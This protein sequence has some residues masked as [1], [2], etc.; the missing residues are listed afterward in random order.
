LAS[1]HPNQAFAH[2]ATCVSVELNELASCSAV[3]WTPSAAGPTYHEHAGA[4]TK[5][6]T[7]CET[8][9]YWG[10]RPSRARDWS[11]LSR[12]RRVRPARSPAGPS[13]R[14]ADYATRRGAAFVRTANGGHQHARRH[15]RPPAGRCRRRWTNSTRIR[16]RSCPRSGGTYAGPRGTYGDER[17]VARLA[18]GRR[19]WRKWTLTMHCAGQIATSRV[20]CA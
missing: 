6:G 19:V 5:E 16:A 12:A 18:S 8:E 14:K 7:R 17:D 11:P 20:S 13:R 9:G 15:D 1:H 2:L 4:V 3:L 10:R